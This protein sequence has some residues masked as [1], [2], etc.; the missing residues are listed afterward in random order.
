MPAYVF[1]RFPLTTTMPAYVFRR[2]PLTTTMP[3]YVF[4][5]FPLT[6]TR[7]SPNCPSVHDDVGVPV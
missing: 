5:R 4:R 3:A 2:F 6:T 7:F 1:R